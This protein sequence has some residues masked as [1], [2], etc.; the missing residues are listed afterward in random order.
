MMKLNI[1]LFG[2]E[3]EKPE[4]PNPAYTADPVQGE[5]PDAPVPEGTTEVP[6]AGDPVSTIRDYKTSYSDNYFIDT[7]NDGKIGNEE[8][9]AGYNQMVSAFEDFKEL[10]TGLDPRGIMR[11]LDDEVKVAIIDKAI[12]TITEDEAYKNFKSLCEANW[13]GQ[14][15]IDFFK[16]V[17]EDQQL[18]CKDMLNEYYSIYN[19]FNEMAESYRNQDVELG[20]NI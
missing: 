11:V 3:I 8:R 5:S 13:K 16:K 17:E 10:T 14:S 4:E 12:T 7:N 20:Q 19:R 6:S 9:T 2:E 1:Q 15:R 18:V